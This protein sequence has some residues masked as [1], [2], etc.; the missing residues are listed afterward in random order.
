[1][2]KRSIGI[3][4]GR[5]H[6]RA[7]QLARTAEGLRIER[8]F[9]LQIRRSTDSPTSVLRSLFLEHD[10][11]HRADVVVSLPS[12]GVFFTDVEVDDPTLAKLQAGDAASIKDSF[13]VDAEDTVVQICSTRPTAGGHRVVLAAASRQTIEREL[14]WLKEA[15]V[16]PAIMDTSVSATRLAVAT[17]HPEILKGTALII[18]AEESTLNLVVTEDD[19]LLLV[20]N[21]LIGVRG[22]PG[23]EPSTQELAGL[24]RSEIQITWRKLFGIDPDAELRVF[25]VAP[26]RMAPALAAALEEQMD[27]RVTSVNPH[28]GVGQP[29]E[30]AGFNIC[31]A[32]GLALRAVATDRN[33]HSDFL[34]AHQTCTRP[35]LSLQKEL[36]FCACLFATIV[37]VWIVGLY[38]RLGRLESQYAIVKTQIERVFRETLPEEKNIANPALQLKQKL[39]ATRAEC[40]STDTGRQGRT[41]PLTVLVALATHAPAEEGLVLDDMLIMGDSVRVSGTCKSFTALSEWQRTIE[42]LPGFQVA[43]ASGPLQKGADGRMHFSLFLSCGKVAQ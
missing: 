24:L 42:E 39:D 30:P 16:R 29:G 43:Q 27:C 40:A 1:M 20:R 2:L 19:Q 3:D 36:A 25:L 9:G 35:G 37:V 6:V 14:G 21:I 17:N 13:P 23:G 10:F 41:S 8:T 31:V 12:H 4:F 38:V 34:A 15:K 28:A 7:V 5:H 33:G 22:G 11:D 32:E 26:S 18:Y